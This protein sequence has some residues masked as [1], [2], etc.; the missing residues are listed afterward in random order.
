MD[1]LVNSNSNQDMGS[2]HNICTI[3]PNEEIIYTSEKTSSLNFRT[4]SSSSNIE[5][6]IPRPLLLSKTKQVN[7][8]MFNFS[9][10]FLVH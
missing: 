7:V 10:I 3:A 9:Q 4:T 1:A 6:V 8:K 5:N 2:E